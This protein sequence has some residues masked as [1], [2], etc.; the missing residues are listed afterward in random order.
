MHFLFI[1]LFNYSIYSILFWI[2]FRCKKYRL[3]NPILYKVVLLVFLVPTWHHTCL[4]LTKAQGFCDDP[5]L[6][7]STSAAI[8]KWY[9]LAN[10]FLSKLAIG[11]WWWHKFINLYWSMESYQSLI[12]LP[13]TSESL[14][15][16]IILISEKVRKKENITQMPRILVVFRVWFIKYLCFFSAY[17]SI[18]LPFP[19]WSRMAML[20][21]LPNN[22]YHFR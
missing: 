14:V 3:D 19:L 11:K 4:S 13:D 22:M 6:L 7:L 17:G 18:V 16:K 15:W 20:L 2:I 12:P 8:E 5:H 21:V 10:P 1:L 9:H